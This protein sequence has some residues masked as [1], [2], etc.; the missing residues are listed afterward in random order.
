MD[1][2]EVIYTKTTPIAYSENG[3]SNA[4]W[5]EGDALPL[6]HSLHKYSAQFK[7][8]FELN[9]LLAHLNIELQKSKANGEKHR[10]HVLLEQK[11]TWQ[12]QMRKIKSGYS[13][14]IHCSRCWWK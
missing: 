8:L 7:E 11:R 4:R 12:E 6:H 10:C 2:S 5:N 13:K 3:Y 1:E 9:I 14:G